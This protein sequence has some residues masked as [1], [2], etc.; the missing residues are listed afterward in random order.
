MTEEEYKET[1]EISHLEQGD[2]DY[3]KVTQES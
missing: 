3:I 1:V 2:L